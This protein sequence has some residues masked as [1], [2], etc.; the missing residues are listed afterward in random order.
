MKNL[1]KLVL[2][3][4]ILSGVSLSYASASASQT[5][6]MQKPKKGGNATPEKKAEM[7]TQKLVQEL[8]LNKD[9]EAKVL[10]V[11]KAFFAKQT[12]L[13][14]KMEAAGDD[15]KEAVKKEMKKAGN[16]RNK[17]LE[18]IL[19]PEQAKKMKEMAQEKKK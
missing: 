5:I 14:A 9:Q 10:E 3:L 15:A 6:E 19:T 8:G 12:E 11:Y 18:A 13:K 7:Q 4:F 2:V 17:Q 16:E 1:V